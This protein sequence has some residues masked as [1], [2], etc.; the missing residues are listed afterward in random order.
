[1]EKKPDYFLF[2]KFLVI[3][4]DKRYR[5]KDI[6]GYRF[7][8]LV[9]IERVNN[10]KNGNMMW[11]CLCD[12][13]NETIVYAN[14]LQ[15]GM[16]QSCGC[17]R[18]ERVSDA[19]R[20]DVSGRRFGRLVAIDSFREGTNNWFSWNCLCDCGNTTVVSVTSLL[21]GHTKSCGCFNR[22]SAANRLRGTNNPNWNNG[23][24]Y[25]PYCPKFN[26][27]LKRRIRTFFDYQCIICGKSTDE[28]NEELCCHHVEY[29]KAS[30]CDGKEVHFAAACRK[31]HSRMHG[32]QRNREMWQEILHRIIDEIYDG[33]SYYT[34]NEYQKLCSLNVPKRIRPV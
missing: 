5:Y 14:G 12:C 19:N 31:C 7:G 15:N 6:V 27:D 23:I 32:S 16:V 33:K 29:N 11:K 28:N 8:R 4:L 3:C 9:I 10:D 25:E 30:C 26:N 1:V 24:S 2:Y 34:K 21:S 18:N 22:E 17:L 20:K 13:G